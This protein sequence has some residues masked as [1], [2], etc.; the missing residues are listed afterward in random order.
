MFWT[1]EIPTR[2]HFGPKKYPR[3]EISDPSRYDGTTDPR[4]PPETFSFLKKIMAFSLD[5]MF[6][7]YNVYNHPL[8]KIYSLK[9]IEYIIEIDFRNPRSNCLEQF[10]LIIQFYTFRVDLVLRMWYFFIFFLSL[11]LLFFFLYIF[12][13]KNEINPLLSSLMYN[14]QLNSRLE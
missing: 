6:I 13:C 8:S 14:F 4:D 12:L 10:L 5:K 3:K 7:V 9:Q 1:H 11:I 2:K